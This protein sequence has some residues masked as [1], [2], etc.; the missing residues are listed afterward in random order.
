MLATS[1]TR[2]T[3]IQRRNQTGDG[4]EW[5][6]FKR[7]WARKLTGPGGEIFGNA[8]TLNNTDAR[9]QGPWTAGIDPTMRLVDGSEIWNIVQVETDDETGRDYLFLR[10]AGGTDE[11]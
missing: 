11:G 6:T 3:T 8:Q 4:F 1:F 9:Y 7:W 10:V 5:V 2:L